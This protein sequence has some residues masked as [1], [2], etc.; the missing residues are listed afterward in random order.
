MVAVLLL[1]VA[2]MVW[3]EAKRRNWPEPTAYVVED[4]VTFISDLLGSDTALRRSDIKRIIEWEVFYL[5]G[6]AQDRRWRPV[7]TVAGG[8]GP[9]IDFIATEI[10]ERHGA[11]YPRDEIGRVLEGEGQYLL[12]IGAIGDVVEVTA[13]GAIEEGEPE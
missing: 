2:A 9:A 3:Q 11:V 8:H 5:Q 13:L 7:E 12:S 4:A 1:I 6:L 10:A